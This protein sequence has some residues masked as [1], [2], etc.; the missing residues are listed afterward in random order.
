MLGKDG[1]MVF[2][3]HSKVNMLATKDIS[4]EIGREGSGTSLGIKAA[5]CIL[6][7]QVVMECS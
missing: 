5:D 3:N 4:L 7:V 1:V 6:G 2:N